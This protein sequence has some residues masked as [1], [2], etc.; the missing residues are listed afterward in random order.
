MFSISH[1]ELP[2]IYAIN[3]E[4]Q[5]R[6]GFTL[7]EDRIKKVIQKDVNNY[8]MVK[9][10]GSVKTKG[11]YLTYGITEVGAW[12]INNNAII[13]KK[14]I[15]DY[16]IKNI[17]AEKTIN[18][19]DNIFE[20][21]LIAKAG[22]KYKEA[23]HM[24]GKEKLPVQKVNRVY[25]SKDVRYGKLY[26]VKAEDERKAKIESLPDHCIIDNGNHLTIKD[27]DKQWYINMAKK[28]IDD[29]LNKD[30]DQNNLFESEDL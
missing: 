18:G 3:T 4:W 22:T 13:V 8:I 6:T 11:A 17:P 29:F 15:V 9:E 19:C 26:K 21:Q 16:F 10:D 5:N 23:Y 2:H 25:A 12:N 28:R 27:I 24:V 7:E 20:F 1:T 30:S 14:A